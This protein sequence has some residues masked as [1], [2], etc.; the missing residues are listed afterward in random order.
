MLF[1]LILTHMHHTYHL[2][3]LID[4]VLWKTSGIDLQVMLMGEHKT[5]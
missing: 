2:G 3:M 5:R 1:I 4:N